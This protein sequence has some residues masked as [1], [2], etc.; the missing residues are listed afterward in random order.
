MPRGNGEWWAEK[1]ARN[2][3]RDL[4]KQRELRDMGWR[5]MVVWEC[6]VRESGPLRREAIDALLEWIQG[7]ARTGV[8][9]GNVTAARPAGT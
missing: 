9:P 4:D 2:V 8:I 7:D 5:V 6:A 1:F 3:A